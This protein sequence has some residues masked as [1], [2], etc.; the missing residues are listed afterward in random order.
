MKELLIEKSIYVYIR[1][2]KILFAEFVLFIN[3]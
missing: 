2:Y 1:L 3:K